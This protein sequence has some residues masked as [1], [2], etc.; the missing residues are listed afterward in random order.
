MD[1]TVAS[2]FLVCSRGFFNLHARVDNERSQEHSDVTD[3]A[4]QGKEEGKRSFIFNL[5]KNFL[6]RRQSSLF[7]QGIQINCQHYLRFCDFGHFDEL[8]DM[9]RVE[10]LI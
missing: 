5:Q 6:I 2:Q 4:L 8:Q 1:G 9:L 3:F 7:P 10:G